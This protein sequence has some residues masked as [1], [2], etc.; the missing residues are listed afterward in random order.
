MDFFYTSEKFNTARCNL[1]LPHTKGEAASIAGAFH[2]CTLG[3]SD[4]NLDALNEDARSWVLEL[5]AYMDTSGLEDPDGR[6]LWEV[7]AQTFSS[8]DQLKISNLVDELAH[9]FGSESQSSLGA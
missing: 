8:D 9:W 6:G 2:E 3:L 5:E 7:K 4:R 1:M